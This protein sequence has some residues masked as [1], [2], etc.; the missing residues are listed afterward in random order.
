MAATV[1]R[2]DTRRRGRVRVRF[3]V[4]IGASA[5]HALCVRARDTGRTEAE[6]A[7]ALLEAALERQRPG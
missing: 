1:T 3:R 6:E 2:L 7:E 4:S 5:Y